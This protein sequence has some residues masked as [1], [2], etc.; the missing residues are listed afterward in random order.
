LEYEGVLN[1]SVGDSLSALHSFDTALERLQSRDFASY[2][3]PELHLRRAEAL[4]ALHRYSEARAACDSALEMLDRPGE[5]LERGHIYRQRGLANHAM[6]RPRDARVDLDRAEVELRRVGD[7]YELTRLLLDRA[8]LYPRETEGAL[9][10]AEEAVT[11]AEQ[12]GVGHLLERARDICDLAQM[13]FN[14]DRRSRQVAQAFAQNRPDVIAKS[15]SMQ[16]VLSR[17]VEYGKA[18]QPVLIMG[19]TGAGKEI[20]AQTVHANSSRG[21]RDLVSLNCAAVPESLIERELF[22]H[23]RGAFTGADRDRDGIVDAAHKGTLFLDEIGELP[24][25]MQ[26]KLLRLK[27]ADIRIIAATHRNLFTM[28]RK[29]QFREDLYYRIAG[30][31]IS[32]PPLRERLEDTVAL[33]NLFMEEQSIEHGWHIWMDRDAWQLVRSFHWPGNVRQ[34]Q[35]VI[36]A[37][38]LIA[39]EKSVIKAEHLRELLAEEFDYFEAER[40]RTSLNYHENIQATERRLIRAALEQSNY[41]RKTAA[42]LLGIGRNTI[43]EKIKKLG[44]EPE[45]PEKSQEA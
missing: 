4:N 16:F 34:L 14:E 33:A 26:A 21:N 13:R 42:Q 44:M 45:L 9:R 22:G 11:L 3:L 12:V 6:A 30:L 1:L 8:E 20:V 37:A 18:L 28:T 40:A 38:C 10:D 29:G 31:R 41:C 23:V 39:G 27:H 7:R 24:L 15:K 32:I 25:A 43:Y 36:R 35:S 17:A 2:E 19:E 5:G